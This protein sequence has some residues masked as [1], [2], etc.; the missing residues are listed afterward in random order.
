MGQDPTLEPFEDLLERDQSDPEVQY[1]IGL[2]YQNGQGVEQNGAQARRW[3]CRAAEQGH[4]EAQALLTQFQASSHS[5]TEI[6]SE[7]TLPDWCLAAEEGN[8]EAQYQVGCHFLKH[9]DTQS[10]GERYLAMAVNQG[11]GKACLE[12]GRRMLQRGEGERAVPL[13]RNGAD[14]GESEAAT[15]LGE[16]YAR[17]LGVEQDLQTAERCLTQGAETGGGDAMVELAVRYSMGDGLPMSRGKAMGWVK[18]AQDAG[19]EHARDQFEQ[20]CAQLQR[21]KE[22]RQKAQEA[23]RAEAF[24]R[25]EETRRAEEAR[26]AQEA[27]QA[28]EARRAE[29]AAHQREK[30][31]Q[32]EN[33]QQEQ[34]QQMAS[35]GEV[36]ILLGVLG[37]LELAAILLRM[38]D[39][40]ALTMVQRLPLLLILI[41]PALLFTGQAWME[42]AGRESWYLGISRHDVVLYGTLAHGLGFVLCTI[43]RYGILVGLLLGLLLWA[44]L[45]GISFVL[46]PLITKTLT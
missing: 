1:Q 29:A 45:L 13:L 12:L 19:M 16:C 8:P 41:A 32:E 21:E 3:L 7:D 24:K 14:C 39:L 25:A 2:C 26:R 36:L 20:R 43:T 34:R 11:H 4:R 15:L 9:P 30:A 10:D 38:V 17:G 18:R 28:E 35:K 22:E 40:S 33:F 46:A 37:I 6:L 5:R 27:K 31:K 44:I 23:R 42:T